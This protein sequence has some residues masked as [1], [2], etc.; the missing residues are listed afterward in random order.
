MSIRVDVNSS[1][2]FHYYWGVV[3]AIMPLYISISGVFDTRSPKDFLLGFSA[4]VSLC[5]F[6]IPKI[7]DIIKLLCGVLVGWIYFTKFDYQNFLWI[8]QSLMFSFALLVGLQFY[9][10]SDD[11]NYPILLNGICVAVVTQAIICFLNKFGFN[12]YLFLF[13]IIGQKV[14]YNKIQGYSGV[15]GSLGNPNIVGSF[16]AVG[17]GAFFRKKWV[18]GLLLVVPAILLTKSHTPVIV[19][20][21]SVA[22]YFSHKRVSVKYLIPG[23]CVVGTFILPLFY[24]SHR[25]SNWVV[26]IP[27]AFRRFFSGWGLGHWPNVSSFYSVG[28]SNFTKMHNEYL[29]LF[30]SLGA[31]GLVICALIYFFIM[32][33]KQRNFLAISIGGMASCFTHFSFHSSPTAL[34][35]MAAL[36]YQGG[37]ND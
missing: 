12:W 19:A 13:D 30:Y 36:F 32:I 15:I 10:I 34:I 4:I 33:S 8:Y 37:D 31:F 14:Q 5:L 26:I 7:N 17:L 24:E 25:T 21:I 29:E 28:P 3:I 16:M 1:L 9:T 2:L 22:A 35:L 20:L 18:W 11:E 23:L 27:R 6:G